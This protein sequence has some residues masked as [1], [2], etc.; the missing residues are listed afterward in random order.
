MA[1]GKRDSNLMKILILLSL[2]LGFFFGKKTVAAK[3]ATE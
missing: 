3:I 1:I 2:A